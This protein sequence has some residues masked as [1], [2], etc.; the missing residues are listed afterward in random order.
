MKNRELKFRIWN[1]TKME[2]NIM[3]GF[4]GTFYVQGMDEKDS[5]SMSQMNTKYYDNI[6]PM[7]FTGL[8]DKNGKEIYE[9]DIV[10]VDQR[11]IIGRPGELFAGFIGYVKY[12]VQAAKYWIMIPKPNKKEAYNELAIGGQ[13]GDENG[14]Q[15]T[16]ME[17]IGN[18]HENAGL[19]AVSR[20]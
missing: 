3:V 9:G 8:K 6:I 16:S 4:L 1:G 14:I 11:K 20:F 17:V 19:L 7:Q 10:S 18:I 15:L 12:S 2:H 5:A 13:Y